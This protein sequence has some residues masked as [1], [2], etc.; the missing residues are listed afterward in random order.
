MSVSKMMIRFESHTGSF[1]WD[2][3]SYTKLMWRN[4][5][6]VKIVIII[7]IIIMI[8]IAKIIT[9]FNSIIVLFIIMIV[10]NIV[11]VIF[12]I[13]MINDQYHTFHGCHRHICH[14]EG[15]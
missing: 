9:V 8:T 6:Q 2:L 7:F 12:I 10:F 5:L 13:N 1:M 11:S 15:A 4:P 14:H 3:E